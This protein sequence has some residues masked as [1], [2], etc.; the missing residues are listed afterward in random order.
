MAEFEYDL[1]QASKL[2][3]PSHKRKSRGSAEL[4]NKSSHGKVEKTHA[5]IQDLGN[6]TSSSEDFDDRGWNKKTNILLEFWMKKC[7]ISSSNHAKR[8]TKLKKL[9]MFL[10]IIY[11]SLGPIGS[12]LSSLTIGTTYSHVESTSSNNITI[13]SLLV[14]VI[15]MASSILA[16]IIAYLKLADNI[17]KENAVVI[18]FE[19]L[20]REMERVAALDIELRPDANTFL[21]DVSEKYTKYQQTVD[22]MEV[23]NKN[24]TDR[25]RQ[26]TEIN[27]QVTN[28]FNKTIQYSS[29]SYS[30]KDKPKEQNK[31]EFPHED[32]KYQQ[33]QVSLPLSQP[34][35]RPK[36]YSTDKG[37]DIDLSTGEREVKNE[38][39]SMSGIVEYSPDKSEIPKSDSQD[40]YKKPERS[41]TDF[42]MRDQE[43][44]FITRTK[45]ERSIKEETNKL[46][47]KYRA[48]QTE[49]QKSNSSPNSSFL[50]T[51][52]Q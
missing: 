19:F 45:S 1:Q 5:K 41:Q 52:K 3:T 33:K 30:D 4:K 11:I 31:K 39:L 36:S 43:D 40:K 46:R 24:W 42:I 29:G 22:V 6:E 51:S 35:I 37:R 50:N 7:I 48:K 49:L 25:L 2:T 38:K 10:M 8:V 13:P 14:A 12:I 23:V 27:T 17:S 18:N 47:S 26:L 34:P 28:N 32:Q 20:A 44:R 16:G 9:N 15:T 21:N